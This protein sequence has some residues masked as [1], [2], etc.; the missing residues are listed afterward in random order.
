VQIQ[1]YLVTLNSLELVSTTGKKVEVLPSPTAVDF[2]QVIDLEAAVLAGRVPAGDYVS[3]NVIVDY[4]KA[5]ITADDGSAKGAALHPLDAHDNPV[6][7]VVPV[8]L[9]LGRH[10]HLLV[11]AKNAALLALD[12]N[13]GAS[14]KVDLPNGNVHLG[15]NLVAD[16]V[17]SGNKWVRLQ[18]AFTSVTPADENFVLTVASSRAINAPAR[19]AV[20]VSLNATT[21]Y[22]IFGEAYT[23]TAGEVVLAALPKGTKIAATGSLHTDHKTLAASAIV[24]GDS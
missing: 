2:A 1:S 24:A 13:L 6:T 21:T 23:G 18:G 16:V 15:T 17:P 5:S 8:T 20:T 19:G 22:R 9:Q 10:Q 14:N 7:G 12:F 11:S 3:A 4:S